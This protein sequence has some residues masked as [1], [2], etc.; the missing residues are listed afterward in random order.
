MTENLNEKQSANRQPE[1]AAK[2]ALIDSIER[3]LD[4]ADQ[5]QLN[6][7]S[8]NT[9]ANQINGVIAWLRN[10]TGNYRQG[11][12]AILTNL[13]SARKKLQTACGEYAKKE[14]SEKFL[15]LVEDGRQF[16]EKAL[17]AW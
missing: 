1:R 5:L 6:G 8:L 2:R 9:F 7:T 13:R 15:T 16:L 14:R 11:K 12:E 3:T 10:D 17:K 4:I